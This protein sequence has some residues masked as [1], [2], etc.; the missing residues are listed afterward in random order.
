MRVRRPYVLLLAIKGGE[1][2]NLLLICGRHPIGKEGILC[3]N[4]DDVLDTFSPQGFITL[5]TKL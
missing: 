5:V 2:T 4:Y 1:V 3:C